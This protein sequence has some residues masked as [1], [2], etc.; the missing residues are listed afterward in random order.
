MKTHEAT[1]F[2]TNWQDVLPHRENVLIEDVDIFKDF[3]VVSERTN[4]LNL[5]KDL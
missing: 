5:I 3:I 2:I 1:T 4:G